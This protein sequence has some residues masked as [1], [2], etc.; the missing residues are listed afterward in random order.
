MANTR[1]EHLMGAR[2][3][4]SAAAS[5]MCFTLKRSGG[6][7][8]EFRL[9]PTDKTD[10]TEQWIQYANDQPS[11]RAREERRPRTA[12]RRGKTTP[13]QGRGSHRDGSAAEWVLPTSGHHANLFDFVTDRCQV[14]STH[15]SRSGLP[16]A[17]CD[18]GRACAL[19]CVPCASPL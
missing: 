4:P 7:R 3:H 6:A 16:L 17:S 8:N 12:S 5:A 9:K 14:E 2:R 11:S 15:S 18:L 1:H 13:G 19:F 10:H